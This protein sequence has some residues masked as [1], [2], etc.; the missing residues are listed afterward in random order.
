MKKEKLTI[1][2]MTL[3]I[4]FLLLFII[5]S[6]V[7]APSYNNFVLE[8]QLEGQRILIYGIINQIQQQGYVSIPLTQNQSLV[9]FPYNGNNQS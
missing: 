7:V 3:I 2:I 4:V 1:F 5:Y 9:L 6:F 8:K